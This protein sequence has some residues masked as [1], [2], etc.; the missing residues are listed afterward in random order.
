[1]RKINA[2]SIPQERALFT[3]KFSLDISK[4]CSFVLCLLIDYFEII[5]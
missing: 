3:E 2:F 1:M 5:S 4:G